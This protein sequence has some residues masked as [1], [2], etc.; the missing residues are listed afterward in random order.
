MT[1]QQWEQIRDDFRRA[2]RVAEDAALQ[3]QTYRLDV[4]TELVIRGRASGFRDGLAIVAA[5]FRGM[6]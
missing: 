1:H 4:S 2:I 6:E 5:V 3:A